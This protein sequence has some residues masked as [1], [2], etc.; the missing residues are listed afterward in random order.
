[1]FFG[2][3]RAGQETFDVLR[4]AE[5]WR[6]R[7][8]VASLSLSGESR[9]GRAVLLAAALDPA[10]AAVA[11]SLPPTDRAQLEA[12]GRSAL[13][14]VPGLLAVGDLP[15]I[16][17][18]IAPRPCRLHVPDVRPYDWTRA[19][20][21]ALGSDALAVSLA[22]SLRSDGGRIDGRLPARRSI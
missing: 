1:W 17:G 10:I 18:L 3:P 7:R 22:R 12:G 14:E 13:A 9:W 15:Q 2:R 21:R 6:S 4:V 11:S 20:Y 5:R 8:D 19:A 16:A